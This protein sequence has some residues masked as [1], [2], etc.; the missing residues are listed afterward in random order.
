MNGIAKIEEGCGISFSIMMVNGKVEDFKLHLITKYNIFREQNEYAFIYIN[1]DQT[2]CIDQNL[3]SGG[4]TGFGLN[5]NLINLK[6]FQMQEKAV[7]VTS[8]IE[9]INIIAK[10]EEQRIK[11]EREA[12]IEKQ[13]ERTRKI[14]E[15][16]TSFSTGIDYID[17]HYEFYRNIAI[18]NSPISSQ[19]KGAYITLHKKGS[20]PFCYIDL[21][22]FITK[23][24]RI[25]AKDFVNAINALGIAIKRDN[26]KKLFAC[27]KARQEEIEKQIRDIKNS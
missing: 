10:Q 19:I 2:Y 6:E 20:D 4:N 15:L 11:A 17:E 18:F 22:D 12:F 26:P 27:L 23:D 7:I 5:N 24:K 21:K 8:D 3:Y 9:E 25:K 1:K 13:T 16:P 14:N